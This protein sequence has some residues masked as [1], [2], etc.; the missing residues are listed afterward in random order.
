MCQ[1]PLCE[2]HRSCPDLIFKEDAATVGVK[3]DIP[4]TILPKSNN[5]NS[6]NKGCENGK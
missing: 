4:K 5:E 1:K 3:N 6:C 2:V